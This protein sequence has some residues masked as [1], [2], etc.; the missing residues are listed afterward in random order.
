[1]LWLVMVLLVV[2]AALRIWDRRCGRHA[3]PRISL[4]PDPFV[5]RRS[6]VRYHAALRP[7]RR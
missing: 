3:A 7:K 4:P 5:D 1:M 2:L 6:M